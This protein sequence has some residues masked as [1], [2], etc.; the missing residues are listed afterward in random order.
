MSAEENSRAICQLE[1]DILVHQTG[2]AHTTVAEDNH[3]K[4]R[5]CI[6]NAHFMG[7]LRVAG[8]TF[9]KTFF[10]D[11]MAVADRES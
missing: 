7:Q 10:R 9:S 1:T 5:S 2:L 11:V 6:R 3:L 8:P 4:I